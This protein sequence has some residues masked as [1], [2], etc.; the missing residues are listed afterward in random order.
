MIKLE[1]KPYF[2]ESQKWFVCC[3]PLKCKEIFI[4]RGL[5]VFIYILSVHVQY[6]C[7]DFQPPKQ[8]VVLEILL[9][10]LFQ[11]AIWRGRSEKHQ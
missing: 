1:T 4:I 2:S 10:K 7:L 3:L 6:F 11:P 9:R 8:H 5:C